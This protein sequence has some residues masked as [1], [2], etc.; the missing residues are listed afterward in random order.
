MHH[1]CALRTVR[2]SL[3]SSRLAAIEA[4]LDQSNLT[5]VRPSPHV[6]GGAGSTR[7]HDQFPSDDASAGVGPEIIVTAQRRGLVGPAERVGGNPS[8]VLASGMASTERLLV[9]GDRSLA[10]S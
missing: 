2:A 7:A 10:Q 3:A 1:A 9:G 8:G 6:R 4:R 5:A